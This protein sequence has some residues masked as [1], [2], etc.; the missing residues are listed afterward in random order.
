MSMP[1]LHRPLWL[2]TWHRIAKESAG[3][4][5]N[6]VSEGERF[7]ELISEIGRSLASQ[8]FLT[9]TSPRPVEDGAER[10]VVLTLQH[11][12]G[13]GEAHASYQ[14]RGIGG[15]I[16][17]PSNSGAGT[18]QAQTVIA[19]GIWNMLV[20]LLAAGG[21]ILLARV[22]LNEIPAEVLGLVKTAT[23][24]PAS[25]GQNAVPEPV[26]PKT[27]APYARLVRQSP[28]EEA[29]REI[30]L[31]RDEMTIGRGEEC[32]A[33]ILHS[34]ISREHARIKKS[35]TGLCAARFAEQK[36]HLH[37]REKGYRKSSQRRD[38]GSYRRRGVYLLRR[39]CVKSKRAECS[40]RLNSRAKFTLV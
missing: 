11:P 1:S 25:T 2:P 6:I 21:L 10:E 13:E 24:S 3:R 17:V 36:R 40:R 9:Y 38:A 30:A 23:S 29:P 5:Y 4:H 32:E 16:V 31:S 28:F 15:A 22:R 35:Q 7:P 26:V 39:E 14:V 8:Y 27:S 33:I 19:Y 12:N 20:P 37:Q 34:S 18:T